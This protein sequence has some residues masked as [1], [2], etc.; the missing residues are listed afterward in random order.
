M[1]DPAYVDFD[2]FGTVFGVI[3]LPANTLFVRGAHK[4]SQPVGSFP[5]YFTHKRAVAEGYALQH[6]EDGDVFTY[7]ASRGLRLFDLRYMTA[8][9]KDALARRVSTLAGPELAA[10]KRACFNCAL[11]YG[12]CSL[13]KQMEVY[14]VLFR[15]LFRDGT[16]KPAAYVE[17]AK[18]YN[19]GLKSPGA[20]G[21]DVID[22]PGVRIGESNI[23]AFSVTVL[24]KMF[25]HIVDGY[26]A[27]V[28]RTPYHPG[29]IMHAECVVFDPTASGMTIV[30]STT[31]ETAK[32]D[33]RAYLDGVT[34][35]PMEPD[36]VVTHISMVGGN[37]SG[38]D[39]EIQRAL[40]TARRYDPSAIFYP[41]RGGG[42]N[43]AAIT[44]KAHK[45]AEALT[46]RHPIVMPRLKV[47]KRI[48]G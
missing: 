2:E 27:P 15:D 36:F 43:A 44:A 26:I 45:F 29:G 38:H 28:L 22:Q 32:R 21:I 6:G 42:S 23:D 35:I 31:Q 7:S 47:S 19:A 33:I 12:T 41:A 11:S 8:V 34:R 1:T 37:T 10:F 16:P 39:V 48:K 17:L 46:Y 24:C 18:F 25:G 14:R 5:M 4:K 30:P 9:Y 40:D 20:P 13:E 3:T